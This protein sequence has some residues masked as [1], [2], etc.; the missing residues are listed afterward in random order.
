M[1]F[2][3]GVMPHSFDYLIPAITRILKVIQTPDARILDIGSGNGALANF[4]SKTSDVVG[5]EPNLYS[6]EIARL[7]YPLI[8][9]YNAGVEDGA[10]K[11]LLSEEKFDI[12]ISTEVVEHLYSPKLLPIFAKKLLKKDGFLIITT[13][14]HGYLKNLLLS[15]FNCWDKH[16]DPNWDGGHIKFWSKKTLSKLLKKNGFKVVAFYGAGRLPFLW[17]PVIVL[18]QEY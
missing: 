16:L 18:A 5:I 2:E 12:C 1:G 15:I 7:A 10:E 8:R 14:Y 3:P 9:F 13:P 4:L 11:M 17:K 6:Y